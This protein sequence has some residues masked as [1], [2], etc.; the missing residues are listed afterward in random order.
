MNDYA[1]LNEDSYQIAII[2]EKIPVEALAAYPLSALEEERNLHMD[3]T[4][5][6]GERSDA[7]MIRYQWAGQYIV[8]NSR[9]LDAAC[10]LGYGSNML[11]SLGYIDSVVAIC[12][13]CFYWDLFHNNS[14]LI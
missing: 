8:P 3:M 6:S 13:Q 12:S 2:M 5:M 7:H 14:N 1:A 11:A 10:G 4:R 9:V